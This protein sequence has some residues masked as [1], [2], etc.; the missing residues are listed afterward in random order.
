MP[1]RSEVLISILHLS[2]YSSNPVLKAKQIT[3]CMCLLEM[4]TDSCNISSQQQYAQA[5]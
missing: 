4:Y 3:V 1:S 5:V 2:K